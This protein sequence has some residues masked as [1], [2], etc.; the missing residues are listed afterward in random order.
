[1]HGYTKQLPLVS[2]QLPLQHVWPGAH[3]ESLLQPHTPFWH[4][5]PAAQALPHAP[6]CSA[7]LSG[8]SQPLAAL[9]SQLP[10]PESQLPSWHCP[11]LQLALAWAGAQVWLQ[12]PQSFAV[13]VERSQ[14]SAGSPLQ[15]AKPGA[16]RRLLHTPAAQSAPLTLAK[17][18]QLLPQAPQLPG[19]FRSASQPSSGRLLQLARPL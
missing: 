17:R 9:P 4:A 11:E 5:L 6:Q 12:L 7:V 10:K 2:M 19:A 8:V 15:S 13:R 3:V 14:P 16:Q 1:M 18:M